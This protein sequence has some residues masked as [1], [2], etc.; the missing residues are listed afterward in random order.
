MRSGAPSTARAAIEPANMPHS[1][2]SSSAMRA[3]SGSKT[4]P[5]WTQR[6]P[7]RMARKRSRRG[8]QFMPRPSRRHLGA[9]GEALHEA[10]LVIVIV[11]GAM[12]GAAIVP[13]RQR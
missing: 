6:F 5:G 1:K 4:E 2:P 10:A 3:E 7:A 13:D 11:D 9:D 12:H 8:V